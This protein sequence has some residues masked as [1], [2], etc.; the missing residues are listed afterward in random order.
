MKS[1]IKWTFRARKIS[2]FWWCFAT[3]FFM[4]V[5]MIFYPSF[6][7]DAEELQK[8][9]ENLPDAAVQLFG[10]STDFFSP[11]GYLNSQ[12]FFIMLPMLLGILSIALGS[13]LLASE[14]QDKTIESILSRPLSRTQFLFAKALSG[15]SVLT[16]VS[17]VSWLAV[18]ILAK[19]VDLEISAWL[20]TK[21]TFVCYLLVLSFGAIAYLLTATGRAKGA[22]I[23]IATLVA[24]GGYIVDSLAGT[25]SWL[26]TPSKL[27]PF[28]YYQSEAILRE[29]YN[30]NN[31]WYFV[32]LITACGVFSWL[33]FRRRD[34]A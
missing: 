10:G 17:V 30:W 26:Q 18:V 2:T 15:V 12:V 32:G 29:T 31:I 25:V 34:L 27:L 33:V 9:F 22:A 4:F 1:V 8:S 14:E 28:N 19:L 5:N 23:G 7:N 13:K 20:L 24:F 11:I 16:L 6:K 3:A 21:T